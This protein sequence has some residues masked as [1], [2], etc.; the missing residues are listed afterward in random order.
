VRRRRTR[1]F[2]EEGFGTPLADILAT[3][4]GCVLLIFMVVVLHIRTSLSQEQA[5][6]SEV[7][8][9][10]VA[11]E[12]GR[13]LAEQAREVERG[14]RT[15]IEEALK[16]V[17]SARGQ[18]QRAL[19]AA[20]DKSRALEQALARAESTAEHAERRYANLENAAR[21]VVT[22]LD[23]HTASPVDIE[24]VIDGTRSMKPSLG[25]TRRNLR[26]AVEALRVVSPTARV[27]V[28][29]FRDQH[30]VESFRLQAHPL[31]GDDQALGRFLKGIEAASTRRD[32]D[33]P[34]WLCGG[35]ARAVKARWRDDAI[36]LMI[37]V[38]DAASQDPSA[39]ACLA[40][41]RR[42]RAAGGQLHVLSTKP[43]GYGRS[44]AVTR[45][46]KTNVLPQHAAIARAGGGVHVEEADSNALMTALLRAAF[47][48]RTRRPL[49]RLR[50]VIG[51]P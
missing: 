18:M 7:L 51:E 48:S 45:D 33:R 1:R 26:A 21:S 12:K 27:G 20:Q 16:D 10:L 47:S 43:R 32:R 25:S 30:E 13:V 29:V 44:R 15:A 34:E 35:I 46:Y 22:E 39:K 38:S 42:F 14:K 2:T 36:K 40:E 3:A 17:R 41:A 5:A 31:T 50:Q 23:P 24:L 4:L 11:N 37:A 6:H 9:Q 28:V 19:V 8:A 49:E